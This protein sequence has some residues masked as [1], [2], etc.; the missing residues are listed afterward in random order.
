ML[1]CT[2]WLRD[3]PIESP[4]L[5]H[6]KANSKKTRKQ[7]HQCN[8][9]S[10]NSRQNVGMETAGDLYRAAAGS[11]KHQAC[12]TSYW[13]QLLLQK[14]KFTFNTVYPLRTTKLRLA[15]SCCLKRTSGS[16]YSSYL[17]RFLWFCFIFF[18]R[19]EEQ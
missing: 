10:S 18:A 4:L 1:G 2:P 12:W 6:N 7:S 3:R 17:S 13:S 19:R 15:L 16:I 8:V 14:L 9:S 11:G 5:A